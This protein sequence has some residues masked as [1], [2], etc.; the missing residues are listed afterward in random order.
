MNPYSVLGI[1]ESCSDSEIKAAFRRLAKE[2]H[3]DLNGSDQTTLVKFR[4]IAEAYS[5][6]SNTERKTEYDNMRNS[7]F[8]S[9]I[10]SERTAAY[11]SNYSAQQI[12]YFISELYAKVRPLKRR[13][14]SNLIKGTSWAIGGVLVTYFSY[15]Y[16]HE[17]GGRYFVT[18]GAILFGGIQAIRSLYY[19][20]VINRV[21]ENSEEELWR[22]IG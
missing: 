4:E 6:L 9:D 15:S 20:T 1:S 13:A 16:A 10:Q 3:P 14:V 21:V 17:T 22:H 8:P 5:L 7:K 18:W 19:Y 12:E 11:T 2:T